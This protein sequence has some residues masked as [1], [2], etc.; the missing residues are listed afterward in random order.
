MC[1]VWG[2]G[3]GCVEY[4]VWGVGVWG[5]GYGGVDKIIHHHTTHKGSRFSPVT[6]R[7]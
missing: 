7:W 4:G 5:V 2:V 6:F 3:C 1:E